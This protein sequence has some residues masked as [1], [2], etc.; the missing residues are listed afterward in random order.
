MDPALLTPLAISLGLG[1]LVGLQRQWKSSELAGIRTFPLVTLLGTLCGMLAH[2]HGG[3]ILGAGLIAIAAML[4]IGNIAKLRSGQNDPGLT[5][6]MAALVMYGVG[7][8]LA[9]G[10]SRQFLFSQPRSEAR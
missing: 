5:T 7:A 4:V 6:E 1:L 2:S 3:W 10:R 9:D 8:A